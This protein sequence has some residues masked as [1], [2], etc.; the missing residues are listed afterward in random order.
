MLGLLRW[1]QVYKS[2]SDDSMTNQV[3]IFIGC[4]YL[5]SKRREG[6]V[7]FVSFFSILAMSLGVMTLITVLSV[8][9]GFDHEIKTR[10][11]QVIPHATV[12]GSS[13]G[14]GQDG[15]Y[16]WELATDNIAA[17]PNVA[18]VVPYIGGQAML[19]Y[20]GRMQGVSMQG[21]RPEDSAIKSSLGEHMLMGSLSALQAGQYKVVSRGQVR[22]PI[23][24]G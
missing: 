21:I 22:L 18:A 13:A 14:R 19:T 8:M 9:N 11:L 23:G 24:F 1:G 7:S 3:S 5:F 17:L 4:R 15:I 2:V 16:D 12:N 6:F 10:I 20:R